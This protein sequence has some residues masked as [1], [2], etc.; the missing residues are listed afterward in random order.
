MGS[1]TLIVGAVLACAPIVATGQTGF[2]IGT[3]SILHPTIAVEARYDDNVSLRNGGD[4]DWIGIIT[5]GLELNYNGGQSTASLILTEEILRYSDATGYDNE[6]FAAVGQYKFEGALT[7]VNANAVYRQ[8]AQGS[9]TIQ[10]LD[11]TYRHDIGN[12]SIDVDSSITAKTRLGVG[13][14]YNLTSFK[15]AGFADN[16]N[17]GVPIDLYYEVTPKVDVSVGYRY[18]RTL[19]DSVPTSTYTAD[20][21]DHFFN[22]GARGEFTPKLKG[23]MRFGYG[24]RSFDEVPLGGNDSTDQFSFSA[25]L[26]YAYSPK[27]SVDVAASN[28]FSTSINGVSR[29][30]LSFRCGGK[31][32]IDPQWAVYAGLSYQ[33]SDYDTNRSDD[34][35]SGDVSVVY[36]VNMN[37][38]VRGAYIHRTS[39][40]TYEDFDFNNN[41]FSLGLSFRY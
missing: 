10:N 21:K 17:Y 2:A 36:A 15:D 41:V 35:V 18:R 29:E 38:S 31:F 20:S 16:R 3:D 5:P 4:S 19:V 32:E 6:L 14:F 12:F 26:I 27:I 22:V 33:A 8:L 7:K 23:Q 40:S 28:D 39:Y 1:K 13:A 30:E 24:T 34:F 11:Q 9:T 25:S 37:L